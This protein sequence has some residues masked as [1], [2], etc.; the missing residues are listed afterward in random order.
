MPSGEY[1]TQI[2]P[3]VHGMSIVMICQNSIT[4]VDLYT[5]TFVIVANYV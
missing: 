1:C 2:L 4:N 5:F 3:D